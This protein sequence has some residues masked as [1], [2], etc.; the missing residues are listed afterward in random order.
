VPLGATHSANSQNMNSKWA[1]VCKAKCVAFLR[2]MIGFRCLWV[3]RSARILRTGTSSG[4]QYGAKMCGFLQKNDRVQVYVG[5]TLSANSQNR[6]LKWASVW[7]AKCVD[8][9]RTIIGFRCLWVRRSARIRRTG[10][11]SGHQH[12]TKMCG[13]PSEN[14]RVQVSGGATLSAN[15]QNRNLKWASVWRAKCVDFLRQMTGFRC[16]WV[17]RSA[18]I[19]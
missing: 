1:S 14:D 7:R 18:R 8:F 19:R 6:N 16:L 3:R 5:A 11:E 13:C 4:P 15:S 17:R 10:T 2:K 12:G 9:L